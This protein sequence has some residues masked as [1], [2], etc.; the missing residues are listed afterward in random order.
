MRIIFWS[1]LLLLIAPQWTRGDLTFVQTL[2]TFRGGASLGKEQVTMRISGQRIRLDQGQSFTSIILANRKVT[3]SISHEARKYIVLSHDLVDVPKAEEND[4]LEGASIKDTGETEWIGGFLC[5]RVRI[6]DPSGIATEL[7]MASG[8]LD[9]K[10]FYKEFKSFM[11]FGRGPGL[12]NVEKHPELKGVPMRVVESRKGK[13]Q[14][15]ATIVRLSTDKIP[16][17]TFEIPAGYSEMKPSDFAPVPPLR[18]ESG[19]KK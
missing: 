15:Q 8:A 7:W 6:L 13:I 5:R 3:Y 17:E 11:E 19:Q 14:R 18:S 12:S 9:T 10:A 1:L 4:S 16:E 2:E